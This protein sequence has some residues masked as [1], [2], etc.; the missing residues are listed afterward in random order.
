M[1]ERSLKAKQTKYFVT[2]SVG[3]VGMHVC[4]HLLK[5]GHTVIGVDNY[6]DY[7]NVDLKK[8]RSKILRRHKGYT[9][10]YLDIA[11][12]SC[13]NEVISEH[14][15]DVVIH[16]A[17]Q[18]GVRES[19]HSPEKYLS[20]NI[21][22]TFN[23]LEAIKSED[24]EHFLFSSTSSVYGA[25]KTQPFRES[26]STLSP[27]SFYAASKSACEKMLHS[28]SHLYSIPTTVF[29]FFTV[30]GPW[31]RPDMALMKFANAIQ[32]SDPIDVYN[33]GNMRRDFTYID[34]LAKAVFKLSE[35]IPFLV[36]NVDTRHC[37][38]TG[39]FRIVNIG[40]GS[41]T[42]L[43]R[44]IELIELGLGKTAQKN[45]LPIQPGEVVETLAS[46][47]LLY[48]ITGFRPSTPPEVGVARF[49]DWFLE[50]RTA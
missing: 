3:F 20:S 36:N 37:F 44:Y 13:V 7:Y 40:N 9:E 6:D 27:L 22:G 48:S 2:G 18:A 25:N 28:Y 5:A 17:G 11:E 31:G 4:Q 30:Y 50:Y 41:S 47:D 32:N 12:K 26:D 46:N 24:I 8:E 49:C 45:L 33:F 42:E 10:V 23:L 29:R 34:D 19:I 14:Q 15:P 1:N 21:V 39:P 16:L 43:N 38:S 35:A